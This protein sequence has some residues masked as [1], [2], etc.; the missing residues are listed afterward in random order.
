MTSERI[1]VSG[2]VKPGTLFARYRIV[3]IDAPGRYPTVLEL[4]FAS[5][6]LERSGVK[7][8]AVYFDGDLIHYE[9]GQNG[10]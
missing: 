4:H 5:V 6:R 9:D 1:E 8:F 3:E 2:N 7:R 10:R